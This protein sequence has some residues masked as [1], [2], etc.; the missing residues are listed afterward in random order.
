MHLSTV[1]NYL[2]IILMVIPV[3]LISQTNIMLNFNAGY[4][5]VNMEDVNKDMEDTYDLLRTANIN[6]SKPEEV[7]GGL[8]VDGSFGIK[9]N[10]LIF[11]VSASYINANGN[12]TYSDITGS[13]EEEYKLSTIELMGFVGV[14]LPI[15]EILSFEFRGAAG[16]GLAKVDYTGAA[17]FFN[18][19]SQNINN[20]GELS[21]GYFSGRL[22][23]G[24]VFDLSGV[25]LNTMFGYRIANAGELEGDFTENGLSVNDRPLYNVRGNAIEFDYSGIFFAGGISIIL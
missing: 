20:E 10:K 8:F 7:N 22:S 25:L 4:A 16:Y 3:Q 18:N 17:S 13:L 19:T 11:G 6:A 2:V 9:I 21:G 24:F 5:S 14:N 1:K 23:G 15:T 12:I